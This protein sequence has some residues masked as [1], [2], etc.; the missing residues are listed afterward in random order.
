MD[1]WIPEYE[2]GL[3]IVDQEK[4]SPK[5]L[6]ILEKVPKGDKMALVSFNGTAITEGGDVVRHNWFDGM[7]LASGAYTDIQLTAE[8]AR[9]LRTAH[10]RMKTGAS[11]QQIMTCWGPEVCPRARTCPYVSLQEEI[12]RSGESR[13]VVPIGRACPIETDIL[14]DAVQKLSIEFDVTGREEEYTDQRFI[15]ELAEIELLESRVNAK[16]ASEPELQ[17]L[18]EE[19]L[20]STTTTKAGDIVDNYV[21]D[22]ADLMKIKEKLWARKDR[23]RKELVGTRREQRVMT[24]REGENV[25]DASVHMSELMKRV[26]QLQAQITEEKE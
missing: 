7:K 1:E 20:V 15:L 16:L 8:E 11:I 22:V 9:G 13:R 5:K 4:P 18:T 6:P 2:D 21:K 12:D 14:H 23:L 25:K 24:A 3:P 10:Q 26:K 17:G 19:K